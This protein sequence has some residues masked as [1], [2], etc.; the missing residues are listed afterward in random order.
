MIKF[1]FL[2]L[3]FFVFIQSRPAS[4]FELDLNALEARGGFFS[5]TEGALLSGGFFWAP[6]ALLFHS[7]LG[8]VYLGARGG[9]WFLKDQIGTLAPGFS[10]QFAPRYRFPFWG[11]SFMFF[12][13]T[14][15]AFVLDSGFVERGGAISLELLHSFYGI[16]EV[17]LQ[18]AQLLSN[19]HSNYYGIQLIWR[20]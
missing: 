10:A 11:V 1:G 4:S 7:S 16:H 5:Q 8:R 17:G 18:F 3:I 15:F 9:Y 12:M 20:W 2:I 19:V 14:G 13:G 6:E